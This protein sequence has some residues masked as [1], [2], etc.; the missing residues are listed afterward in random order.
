MRSLHI[1]QRLTRPSLPIYKRI[2]VDDRIKNR[3]KIVCYE[4]ETI[5]RITESVAKANIKLAL[6]AAGGTVYFPDGVRLGRTSAVGRDSDRD[7]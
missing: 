3:V 6:Y 5:K 1:M 2:E 4:Q 7:E